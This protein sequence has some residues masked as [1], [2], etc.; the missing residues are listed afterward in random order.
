MSLRHKD[1]DL[2]CRMIEGD[3]A[4]FE[5][6]SD[7]HLPA[8][9][10]FAMRRLNGN[11]ELTRELT[12]STVCKAISK[13]D[14]YRGGSALMTWLC[15]ICRTEIALYFRKRN[16]RGVEV[17]VESE[18]MAAEIATKKADI[19]SPERAAIDSESARMVH[20]A[21]DLLPD[22]YSQVLALKYLEGQSVKAMATILNMSA[23]ATESLLTRARAAFRQRYEEMTA[24]PD[25]GVVS[26]VRNQRSKGARS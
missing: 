16:R 8:L 26:E 20:L 13:L 1:Y 22:N 19:S 2:A 11:R 18:S 23:K 9:Y 3:E 7:H 14:T 4:A 17:E 10:R 24:M 15:A 12:Q 25:S 6:F 21:L 5:E